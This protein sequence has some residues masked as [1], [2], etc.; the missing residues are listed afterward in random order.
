LKVIVVESDVGLIG[1]TAAH[2]FMYLS[3]IGEDQLL[4]C[5][6]CG[7]GA[8][9]Q[10]A[11]F[12]KTTGPEEPL[13]PLERVATPGT[14]TIAALSALLGIPES[15]TAKAAFFTAGDQ[16]IFAV[17]RGDMEVNESKLAA[18]VNVPSLRPASAEDIAAKGIVAG[19]ASPIGVEDVTVVVDDL[20]VRSHNLVAGANE[21][22]YHLLNTN[23]PRDYTPD[24]TVDIADTYDGAPCPD[25]GLPLRM[26]RG[27]EVGNTFKLGTA[28]SDPLNVRFLDADG[29][30]KPVIMASYGIGVGRLLACVAQEHRDERGLIWPVSVA[31]FEVYLVGLDLG[32]DAVRERAESMYRELREA[33]IE[34]LFDDRAERAGVKFNDADLLGIP[35]RLTVSRRSLSG[36]GVEAK[37]RAG[38]EATV[39]A[40]SEVVGYV[41]RELERLGSAL[42]PTI[43]PR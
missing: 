31:P 14:Q 36:G 22:G 4:L 42:E 40:V 29:E 32:E 39:L 23:V 38:G 18:A 27:V 25:C 16:F 21:P 15:R 17:V 13:R 11:T 34:V 43:P 3:E 41:E 35:V 7:Y 9:R 5:D 1:G 10:I 26:A 30:T 33:G 8:N 12:R 20:V 2:E 24:I 37:P 28:Y 6:A 19:Y